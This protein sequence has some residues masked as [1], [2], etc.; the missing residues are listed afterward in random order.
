MQPPEL[1]FSMENRC[2]GGGQ[3]LLNPL[4]SGHFSQWNCYIFPLLCDL[5]CHLKSTASK[6]LQKQTQR[7]QLNILLKLFPQLQKWKTCLTKD[8]LCLRGVCKSNWKANLCLPIPLEQCKEAGGPLS[9]HFLVGR[10]GIGASTTKMERGSSGSRLGVKGILDPLPSHTDTGACT[11]SA[12]DA[13]R[14]SLPYEWTVGEW[15]WLSV[16]KH[17]KGNGLRCS[18]SP[19]PA[20]SFKNAV[21]AMTMWG[22]KRTVGSTCTK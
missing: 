15:G 12:C 22:E 21:S 4:V 8:L 17:R 16:E 13:I 7:K 1:E 14:I 10:K 19:V 9:T 3:E 11:Q 6:Q 18:T 20:F 2:L 5:E